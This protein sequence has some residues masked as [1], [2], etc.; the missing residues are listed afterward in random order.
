MAETGAVPDRFTGSRPAEPV[1]ASWQ[2]LAARSALGQRIRISLLMV[3][4]ITVSVPIILPYFWMVVIS[5]SAR[6]GGVESGVLW[7]SC[8]ILVPA[9]VIYSL[10]HIALK[11]VRD[12]A[13]AAVA[14]GGAA[15][16]LLAVTV[17]PDLHLH[18]YRFLVEPNVVEELRG[19]AT[20]GGQFPWVWDAFVNS[21][22]LASAQT[23]IV[24]TVSTL[25]GYYLSRF[26]FFGRAGF[27]QTLLVLQA[28]PA[29]T[30]VIPIFL[31]IHWVGL[32]NT[33]WGPMLV[34]TALELPF[35][36]F[37]MKGFFDAVPWDI[38]MSAISDGATRRQAFRMVV[39]PQVRVG[40]IAIGIFSFIKGWEEYVF[41]TAL[42]TGNSYWVMSTYIYYVELD[43]M[44]VDYGL[45]AA[46]ATFYVLPSLLLY[47]F[48]QKYLTQMTLGG[49]KG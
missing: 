11:R 4:L 49:V 40:M 34:I 42:R 43:V 37:I 16:L 19:A 28:F 24:V 41:V 38:E 32:L 33:L 18:N 31:I 15:V 21:L 2:A 13:M 35:F 7:R 48:C 17:G 26:A 46:V 25:A 9:A 22:F 23:V 8:A 36:I 30:L 45:V 44:G 10:A 3:F 1:G 14:V 6:T 12:R 29:M 5:F 20:A 27:L 39:L 47:L